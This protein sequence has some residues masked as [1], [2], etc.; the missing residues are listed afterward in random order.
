MCIGCV[1]ALLHVDEAGAESTEGMKQ[2]ARS[3]AWFCLACRNGFPISEPLAVYQL[4]KTSEAQHK[5]R[6][7]LAGIKQASW[8]VANTSPGFEV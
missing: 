8:P 1:K 2:F 4:P 7:V 3:T 5:R 6:L